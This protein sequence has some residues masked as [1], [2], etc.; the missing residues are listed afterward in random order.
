MAAVRLPDEVNSIRLKQRL[1]EKYQME[2]LLIEWNG[3]KLILVSFQAYNLQ[4]D[5]DALLAA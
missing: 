2:I 4:D 1:Y 5:L 3:L